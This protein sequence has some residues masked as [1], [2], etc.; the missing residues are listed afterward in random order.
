[1]KLPKISIKS[2]VLTATRNLADGFETITVVLLPI[3]L[4]WSVLYSTI[5]F[6]LEILDGVLGPA[7]NYDR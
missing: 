1:M 5:C 7:E 4:F 2:G 3:V 6:V